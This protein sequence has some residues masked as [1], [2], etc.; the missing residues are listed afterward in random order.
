[1]TTSLCNYKD[2]FGKPGE[3]AH[4]K[5]IAGFAA[6]DI[7]FTI[8]AVFLIWKFLKYKTLTSF[9]V[10]LLITFIIAEIMHYMFCVKTKFMEVTG[11]IK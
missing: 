4:K 7:I 11:L 1:M 9:L 5:R 6:I 10:I 3:G 8:L 2:I